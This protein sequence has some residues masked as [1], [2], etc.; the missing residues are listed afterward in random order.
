MAEET[1]KQVQ[2]KQKSQAYKSWQ[3]KKDTGD[4]KF[5][6]FEYFNEPQ[7]VSKGHFTN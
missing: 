3:E 7:E 4:E 1:D 2:A 5:N 6:P